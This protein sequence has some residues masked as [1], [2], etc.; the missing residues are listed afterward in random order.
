MDLRG[1]IERSTTQIREYYSKDSTHTIWR[2]GGNF[3]ATGEQ[4]KSRKRS[5]WATLSESLGPWGISTVTIA[6]P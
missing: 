3:T 1:L 4:Q 2:P 5:K 6:E